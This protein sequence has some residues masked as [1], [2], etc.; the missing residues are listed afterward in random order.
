MRLFAVLCCVLCFMNIGAND[1]FIEFSL[2]KHST[3]KINFNEKTKVLN[4]STASA[5][6]DVNLK[7]CI[8][9]HCSMKSMKFADNKMNLALSVPRYVSHSLSSYKKGRYTLTVKDYIKKKS[10]RLEKKPYI[11]IVDPG[12]GGG[13]P[14]AISAQGVYEKN[15]TLAIGTLLANKLNQCQGIRAILTRSSDKTV[16][17]RDRLRSTVKHSADLFISIHADAFIN[18]QAK[19]ISVYALSEKGST[20]AAASWLATRENKSFIMEVGGVKIKNKALQ[21][22]IFDLSQKATNKKSI[23][24][25]SSV[26]KQLGSVSSL[27][28]ITVE[29]AAF[30]VLKSAYTPAILIETG[31]LSNPFEADYLQKPSYQKLI[32]DTIATAVRR[33][34]SN[35]NHNKVIAKPSK[36]AFKIHNVVQ[37]ENLYRIGKRYGVTPATII[38]INKLVSASIFVGQAIK[39]PY[40]E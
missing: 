14:G 24:I 15:I 1:S 33:Y 7:A 28:S 34:A 36:K 22:I 30:V 27:H 5:F 23:A 40:Y 32:A 35:I 8:K 38:N 11:I 21:N 31:F 2:A 6:T 19:G 17:L 16:T 10:V 25:G 4:L 18:K 13:D 29:Q 20:S 26:L 37:G 9:P 12:H 39:V 3:I